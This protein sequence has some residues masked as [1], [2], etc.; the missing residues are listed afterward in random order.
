[1]KG[2]MKIAIGSDHAGFTAKEAVTKFLTSEGHEVSDLGAYNSEPT[3]YPL[4]AEKVAVSVAKGQAERGIVIC[5]NGIGMSIVANKIPGIRAALVTSEKS[6]EQTRAHNDS[7]VLSL[8]GR[9]LP[10]ET[11][12]RLAKI[13]IDTPFSGIDRHQR[14][15]EEILRIE[16]EYDGPLLKK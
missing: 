12:L 6:A 14:R 2:R 15:V 9:D 10:V 5:G 1:M 7:N 16:N 8:A 3:D 11:N 13:W 4:F